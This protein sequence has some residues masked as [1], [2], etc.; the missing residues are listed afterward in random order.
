[1]IVGGVIA[2]HDSPSVSFGIVRG[3]IDQ[4]IRRVMAGKPLGVPRY[5]AVA[6]VMI[7]DSDSPEVV[8]AID[9]ADESEVA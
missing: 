6:L 5:V 9:A 2:A 4:M 8:E 7:A 1:M 3:A